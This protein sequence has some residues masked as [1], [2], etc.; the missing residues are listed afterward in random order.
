MHSLCEK[1]ASSCCQYQR[2]QIN[3]TNL[4]KPGPGLSD[5]VIILV[6]PIYTDL[7]KPEALKKWLHGLTQ[8]YIES[9][10]SMIWERAPK[11]T[12]ISLEKMK[13]AVYDAVGCFNDGRKSSLELLRHVGISPGCYTTNLCSILNSRRQKRA[14]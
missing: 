3:G 12:Y 11:N 13:F 10:N 4:F 8:N 2:D 6:K 1:S 14:S 5:D 7:I 9:F